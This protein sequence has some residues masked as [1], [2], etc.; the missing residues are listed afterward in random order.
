MPKGQKPRERKQTRK[1]VKST[2][3]AQQYTSPRYRQ[4]PVGVDATSVDSPYRSQNKRVGTKTAKA[5]GASSANA[6]I[7]ALK[8]KSRVGR[9]TRSLKG[10]KSVGKK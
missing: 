1:T 8:A 3:G 6:F 2:N 9:K 7:G 4:D 10:T 5:Y